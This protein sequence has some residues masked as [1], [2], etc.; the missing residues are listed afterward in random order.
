LS[1]TSKTEIER[2]GPTV[3]HALAQVLAG[4]PCEFADNGLPEPWKGLIQ[5]LAELPVD[6]RLPAFEAGLK[7]IPGTDP[8]E[9]A[10]LV[11]A[12]DPTLPEAGNPNSFLFPP[13]YREKTETNSKAPKTV[14]LADFLRQKDA[15]IDWCVNQILPVGG[16]GILAGPAGYGKSWMLL[17]LAIECARGGRWLGQFST[18]KSSVLYI[19]EESSPGLLRHRLRKLLNA[20]KLHPHDL[21]ICFCIGQGIC[22][23]QKGSAE[24]L[25]KVIVQLQPSLVIID[26]LIRVHHSEENSASEMS[27]VFAV[28]KDMTR[29]SGCAFLFADH[30]RKPGGYG[31]SLDLLL[32]GSSDKVAFVDTLLSLQRKDKA[33]IVEHSKSRFAEPVPSFVV[34]IEDP[35]PE[36]T[37][38]LYV[39]DA[40]AAQQAGRLAEIQGFLEMAIP[41]GEWIARKHLAAEAKE[42]RISIK[43]LDEGLKAL[44]VD[45]ILIREDRPPINGPGRKA[46]YYRRPADLNSFHVSPLIGKETETNSE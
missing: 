17:D 11:F 2:Y 7:D 39:G 31:T 23:D 9:L 10:R 27:R 28:V 35:F 6:G 26:S 22:L 16:V 25:A 20:K 29:E 33:L 13:I 42:K 36:A 30:Q 38:V 34:R 21:N 18:A 4:I 15:K 40:D 19:D 32:R 37:T 5:R 46:A 8:E 1:T 3:V 44:E 14:T 24:A 12:V 43:T 45:R 41:P